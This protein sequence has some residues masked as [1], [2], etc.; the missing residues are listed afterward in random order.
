MNTEKMKEGLKCKRT[1]QQDRPS[2]AL[3]QTVFIIFCFFSSL[4][5]KNI[6]KETIFFM[7]TVTTRSDNGMNI[8]REG[9]K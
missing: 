9:Q 4:P 1:I 7:E 8:K 5:A 2:E 6:E 3:N